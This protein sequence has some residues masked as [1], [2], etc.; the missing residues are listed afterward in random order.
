MPVHINGW[1]KPPVLRY[2]LVKKRLIGRFLN[3]Q[4]RILRF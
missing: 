2:E 4:E 3:F 1:V